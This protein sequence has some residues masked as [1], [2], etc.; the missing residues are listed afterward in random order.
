[1]SRLSTRLTTARKRLMQPGLKLMQALSMRAKLALVAT[2][3]MVPT[4]LLTLG[5]LTDTQQRVQLLQQMQQGLRLQGTLEH[6]RYELQ[7][8]RALALRAAAGDQTAAGLR[9]EVQQAMAAHARVMADSLA[10]EGPESL[11]QGWAALAPRLAALSTSAG[12]NPATSL[13]AAHNEAIDGLA[14]LARVNA[15]HS[16]L[17]LDPDAE[18][19]YRIELMVT[20]LPPLNEA[21]ARSAAVG[22]VLLMRAAESTPPVGERLQLLADAAAIDRAALQAQVSLSA[23]QRSGSPLPATWAPVTQA[24]D[25]YSTLL[26][27]GFSPD[28]LEL[29]VAALLAATQE[30]QLRL[31]DLAGETKASL[32]AS[33]DSRVSALR[34]QQALASL[35]FAA[36]LAGSLYLIAALVISFHQSLQELLRTTQAVASGDLSTRLE[37]PG[38]DELTRIGSTV[39]G[40]NERLSELVGEIRSSAARVNMAGTQVADGSQQLASRTE[41]QASSLRESVEAINQLSSAAQDN[42]RAARELDSLTEQLSVQAGEGHQAMAETISAV[43]KLQV[44]SR[45]VFEVVGVIDDVAFQTSML[46]LNAAVEAARAGEAGRG[47]AL[48]A[49]EVRTL[50][51]RVGESA[52][53]IRALITQAGDHLQFSGD[54]LGSANG[55]LEGVVHGV[56]DVSSRLRDI[57]QASTEQ[58]DTLVSVAQRVGDLDQI[59]RDNAR[60]VDESTH[61]SQALLERAQVLRDAVASMRLRQGSADEARELL[62]RA[63]AHVLAVGTEPGLKDLHDPAHGFIDRDLYVF[64]LDRDGTYIACGA[65][66]ELVGTS[67]N[68]LPGIRGTPFVSEAWSAAEA[69]GGWVQ[70]EIANPLTGEVTPK[71]SYVRP[72]DERL[73][74]GCGI[75][76][77]VSQ[78]S[79]AKPRAAAWSHKQEQSAVEVY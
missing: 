61:A 47:F 27:D 4:A 64:A 54:K 20:G 42:A 66:P 75:Y 36:G 69:G 76:R 18:G 23:L 9:A 71:E 58:S 15:E 70:Y 24:V 72:L 17:L 10:A 49:S 5:W 43:E 52:D 8:H 38:R 34:R 45:R 73:L 79:A 30:A 28:R 55:A 3:L 50:A 67:V 46:S 77:K 29:P 12:G 40:M 53:E 57:A 21:V 7:K 51:Q 19:Y 63:H 1:M 32:Q 65:K 26:R 31:S 48:V 41:E 6:L 37:L 78:A 13:L 22:T 62:D 14:D 25:A 39:N 11:R 2:C 59:T 60:L 16:G 35:A 68:Q 56:R 44:A 74:L 33:L